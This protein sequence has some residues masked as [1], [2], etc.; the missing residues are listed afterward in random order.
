M[1]NRHVIRLLLAGILLLT[2][3]H[4]LLF[5]KGGSPALL[6]RRTLV[7]DELLEASRITIERKGEPA[8]VLERKEDWRICGPYPARADELPINRL[9]DAL[10]LDP[11]ADTYS[12]EDLL[13]LEKTRDDY[14]L[15]D[16]S[17]KVSVE[18]AGRTETIGFGSRTARG[19]SVFVTR[20]G[21]ST[22]YLVRTN[23]LAAVDLPSEGFRLRSLCPAGTSSVETFELRRGS[24][25]PMTFVRHDGVWKHADKTAASAAHIRTM[26]DQFE[27]AR[28]T[29]FVWPV[30]KP[31]EP[32][33][34]TDSFLTAYGLDPD[35][36]VTVTLRGTGVPDQ[37]VAFGA[38]EKDGKVYALV[39]DREA[40]V[41]VDGALSDFV[42]TTDFSDTHLFP[43]DASNVSYVSLSAGDVKCNLEKNTEDGTWRLSAPISA[44]AEPVVVETLVKRL[45]AL[46]SSDL[47]EEGVVVSLQTN[48]P[49]VT[50]TT[51]SL[52]EDF[53]MTALRSREVF[54][55]SASDI[56]RISVTQGEAKADVV[57][58]DKD[59]RAW[60]VESATRE[61]TVATDAVDHLL[62]EL[63][64]LKAIRIEQLKVKE[65]DLRR[66]GLA[67]PRFTVSVTSAKEYEL[68]RNV[69]IGEKTEGGSFATIGASDA[70]FVLSD[71]TVER[72]TAPLV[73]E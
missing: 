21:D 40:V 2:G 59:L 37:R 11:V 25:M 18:I 35:S 65:D 68:R 61:G 20:E 48:T 29:S 7:G 52:G 44:S 54:R 41:T 8:T 10:V 67:N 14:G 6:P 4:V 51:R 30:G 70:I 45:L 22:V 49:P 62:A 72:L 15:G 3:L 23:V 46:T 33:D 17:V 55:F 28:V 39:Q 26:L 63:N 73:S 27:K 9:L 5:F 12:E 60:K 50:V 24:E 57:A 71:E 69:L 58:Y 64:P 53:A 1:S 38:P 36:A 43:I 32:I 31:N 47:T 19:D 56:R 66:C 34:A 13:K 16:P 42:R